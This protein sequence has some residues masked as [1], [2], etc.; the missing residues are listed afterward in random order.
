MSQ[1]LARDDEFAMI[2]HP[3]QRRLWQLCGDP[4][5]QPQQLLR[6]LME[7]GADP[8][9]LE[10][11]TKWLT[12]SAVH[13]AVM[14]QQEG[15]V[16]AFHEAG[17]SLLV[18]D[19]KGRT[20]AWTALGRGA[21]RMLQLLHEC[22]VDLAQD[23]DAGGATLLHEAA[24]RNQTKLLAPLVDMG[25]PVNAADNHGCTAFHYA[26][27]N[28]EGLKVLVACGADAQ[29]VDHAGASI[30]HKVMDTRWV[31]LDVVLYLLELDVDFSRPNAKGE[32]AMDA[33]LLQRI[34][35]YGEDARGFEQ[36]VFSGVAA[37]RARRALKEVQCPIPTIGP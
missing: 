26:L 33:L 32:T 13:R 1:F 16:R 8:L 14:R 36:A 24:S 27:E 9:R 20:P 2:D 5:E 6:E 4:H 31:P 29:A 23:L 10:T 37:Q 17:V 30:A 18:P 11:V 19:A 34:T 35:R 25:V 7:Q 28:L 21:L 22:G 15:W 12:C 3:A